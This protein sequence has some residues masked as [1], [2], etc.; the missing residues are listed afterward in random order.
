MAPD[1]FR[2]GE[3]PFADPPEARDPVRRLRGRLAA[4]VTIVTSGRADAA[5]GLTVSSLVVAEGEPGLVYMLVG[6]T[7]D[8]YLQI[9]AS[10]RFVI[11]VCSAEDRELADVF[12]GF[13]PNPGGVFAG[14]AVSDSEHGLVLD[15]L[16]TRAYCTLSGAREESYSVLVSG[17]IDRVEA[18]DSDDPLAYFRGRYRTLG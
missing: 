13:R 15:D 5:A 14:S 17:V 2:T 12:A 6:S 1:P 7:T 3:N 10:R 18:G 11:H 4:P 9:E 16:G 8:L